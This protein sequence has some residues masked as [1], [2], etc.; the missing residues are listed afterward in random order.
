MNEK[1]KQREWEEELTV[2]GRRVFEGVA[3]AGP[4]GDVWSR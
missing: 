4:C 1:K 2:E 3:E